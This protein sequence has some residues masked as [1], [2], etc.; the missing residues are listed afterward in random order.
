ML[1]G[2]LQDYY[3]L[4]KL[5]NASL[6]GEIDASKSNVVK[7]VQKLYDAKTRTFK[8]KYGEEIRSL[9]GFV[10][11]NFNHK[12]EQDKINGKKKVDDRPIAKI[13]N[14]DEKDEPP[15]NK[16][17]REEFEQGLYKPRTAKRQSPESNIF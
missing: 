2:L 8:T 7:Y 14:P 10:T 1:V 9:Y 11:N 16:K 6:H 12:T 4:E 3:E 13:Y 5:M 17:V 15:L